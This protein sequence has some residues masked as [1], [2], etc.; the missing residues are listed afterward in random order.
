MQTLSNSTTDEDSTKLEKC[1]AGFTWNGVQTSSNYEDGTPTCRKTTKVGFGHLLT[2][3]WI[4]INKFKPPSY[5]RL[6]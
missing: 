6:D 4:S 1:I 3:N 5:V 2:L